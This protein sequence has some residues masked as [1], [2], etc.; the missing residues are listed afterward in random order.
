[1][2]QIVLGILAHVDS[3]KTTLSEAMLYKTG[4]I[5]SYGRVDHGNAFLDTN[6]IEREKGIT[7]FSSRAVMS[8]GDTSVTLLDTPGHIDFSTET[9][10]ALSV[11]DYCILVISGT[12]GVQ[13]HS[14]TLWKLLERYNIPTFVYFNKMDIS[15]KSK[16]ELLSDIHKN[17]SDNCVELTDTESL[18][19][20]DEELLDEYMSDDTLSTDSI[21]RAIAQRSVF[22]CFFGSAL[23]MQGIDEL[24][25]ALSQYTLMP[26]PTNELGGRVFKISWDNDGN[27]LTHIKI[28]GGALKSKS[29]LDIKDA[30]GNAQKEK[31]DTIRI[32]QGDKFTLT[33]S[34]DQGT[35]CAVTGLSSTFAGM[36]IGFEQNTKTPVLEPVMTYKVDILDDTDVHTA[37]IKLKV[38]EEEDPLLRIDYNELLR[39]INIQLMGEVQIDILRRIIYERFNI[40]VD[41]SEGSISYRETISDTVEGVGHFEPLRHYS[42]V[43]L[44][45]EPA[46][47]GSGIIISSDCSEDLLDKNWQRLILTHIK[48]KTHIGVLTG[49]PITDIKI[50]LASGRA[51]KKHTEG[52]DFRQATYRAIR[53]GLMHAKSVLLEPYYDFKLYVPTQNVGRA[54]TDLTQMG[55]EFTAP[56]QTD[57]TSIISGSAPV[58][59]MRSYHTTLAAYTSGKGR[60]MTSLKGYLPC[61]NADEV[62][63]NIGYNPDSDTENPA[64]SVFCE[65]GAGFNVQWDKVKDYMHLESAL[66]PEPEPADAAENIR[67]Y[68]SGV[69]ND[70]ELL[71]IF[72]KTYGPVK[73][74]VYTALK[75]PTK[76]KQPKPQRYIKQKP[77]LS[78]KTYLLVDG[79]NIIF[80]WDDL[81]KA[82][83]DSLDLAR[84]LLVNRLC[85]YCGF[86]QCELIL[87][88]DAYKVKGGVGSVEKVNNISVVYTKEA[89]T[90]DAYIE[91]VTHELSKKHRVRVA[92]SDGLEQIIILGSGAERVSASEFLSEV[93]DTEQKIR[94][95]INSLD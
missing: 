20:C 64:S 19:L 84:E 52:G 55:A 15:Q 75:T 63:E 23:K 33:D 22:P 16:D 4:S 12:D 42:E 86:A 50:T 11:L 92:T 77:Q 17:L 41:F 79:Y 82:A 28:T 39:Q 93:T 78:G 49:S 62:I 59:E 18:I 8:L 34:A 80:A 81:K 87:V 9:E 71:R 88:F 89:E 44:I 26:H 47:R 37:L 83:E 68:V 61:H 5:R 29:V 32:Y 27:R 60:L 57:D 95:F 24:L 94:N 3:G 72:E 51:H 43:H 14:Q 25:S 76:E 7:I 85:N 48:E 2:K 69:I 45:L 13:S 73:R 58:S 30:D 70:E 56:S 74:K 1:M 35:V 40:R 38:L 53:N 66:K 10:R 65:H 54:M 6:E 90:A 67:E 36:G 21:S 46:K 91:K 31:V